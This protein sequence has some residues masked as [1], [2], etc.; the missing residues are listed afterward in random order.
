[1]HQYEVVLKET[2]SLNHT[3]G[4]VMEEI[5]GVHLVFSLWSSR[6]NQSR[7]PC[8]D[9]IQTMCQVTDARHVLTFP[10]SLFFFYHSSNNMQDLEK[11]FNI[12][13]FKNILKLIALVVIKKRN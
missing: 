3:I 7:L 1:M 4:L 8:Q 9:H 6:D 2:Q 12:N 11:R 5:S 10:P 13:S